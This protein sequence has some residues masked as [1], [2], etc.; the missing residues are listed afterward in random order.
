MQI[1]WRSAGRTM[2]SRCKWHPGFKPSQFNSRQLCYSSH[3]AGQKKRKEKTNVPVY[4]HSHHIYFLG[5]QD[6]TV[7]MKEVG[8]SGKQWEKSKKSSHLM[9]FANQ[10]CDSAIVWSLLFGFKTWM[11][12]CVWW[13]C[14]VPRLGGTSPT[15]QFYTAS[16]L[17]PAFLP[18]LHCAL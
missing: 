16:L 18:G 2:M 6:S 11:M 13:V 10:Q 9:P 12:L 17:V 1:K 15:T 7:E 3:A 8:P 5:W 14:V 4:G